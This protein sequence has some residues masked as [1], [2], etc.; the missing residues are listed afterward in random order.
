MRT[1]SPAL[2]PS[3]GLTVNRPI[4]HARKRPALEAL[5][6]A[7]QTHN[8]YFIICQTI[9]CIGTTSITHVSLSHRAQPRAHVSLRIFLPSAVDVM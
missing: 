6:A 8:N 7:K 9:R 5:D 3:T 4:C 1:L 2:V